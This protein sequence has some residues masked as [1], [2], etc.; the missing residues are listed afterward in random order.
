M[1]DMMTLELL[2]STVSN[3]GADEVGSQLR[4]NGGAPFGRPR[5]AIECKDAATSGSIDEMRTFVARLYDLTILMGHQPH[6][7]TPPPP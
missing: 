7:S 6:L 4:I 2:T 5:L 3:L 1:A